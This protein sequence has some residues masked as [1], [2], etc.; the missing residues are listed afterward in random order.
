MLPPPDFL[1]LLT[2]ETIVCRCEEVTARTLRE[3]LARGCSSM[4]AL[5][6]ATRIGMGLCQ[7]RNCLR[8]LADLVARERRCQ[9]ADL[10]YPRARPPARPVRLGDLLGEDIA[11]AASS[12]TNRP[13]R[14][15]RTLCR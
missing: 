6:G 4:N 12:A 10:A 11:P 1:S 8:T 3:G 13:E 14:R 7:G 5:K 9:P 15:C 2:P